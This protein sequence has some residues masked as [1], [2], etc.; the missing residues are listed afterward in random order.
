[1]QNIPFQA[2]VI[3]CTINKI[4]V[5]TPNRSPANGTFT[6]NHF[7]SNAAFE[8]QGKP[9]KAQPGDCLIHAGNHPQGFL[10]EEDTWS[11]D[12]CVFEGSGIQMMIGGLGLPIGQIF[13]PASTHFVSPLLEKITLEHEHK[14]SRW[15]MIVS[16]GLHELLVKLARHWLKA[17]TQRNGNG[18][19][20]PQEKLAEIRAIVH[21]QLKK[22]WTVP[23]MARLC[24]LSASRF[25]FLYKKSFE[26]SPMEDLIRK[27]IRQA[28]ILLSDTS[29][30]I[31]EIAEESGFEDLQYFYRAFKKRIGATPKN[32]RKRNST[33]SPWRS[34]DEER[35]KLEAI[36]ASSNF[37]GMIGS[38]EKGIPFIQAISGDWSKLG[39]DRKDILEQPL[40]GL[41]HPED[42][43]LV[44]KAS[45]TV[46]SGGLLRDLPLRTRCKNGS[47][48]KIAWTGAASHDTFY[49]SAN[50]KK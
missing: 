36:W 11:S 28:T 38:D 29:K 3:A 37:H 1:M 10:G 25:A 22:Q 39:W 32:V 9:C 18:S 34:Y 26:V 33:A 20:D 46:M 49:F 41:I 7:L 5:A 27:R 14:G 47:Y 6:F 50:F 15:E 12:W 42:S 40:L 45:D 44:E 21:D 31:A 13:R 23:E 19:V 48:C 30:S 43:P 35:G 24:N 17:Q 4:S 2:K 8:L 16:L